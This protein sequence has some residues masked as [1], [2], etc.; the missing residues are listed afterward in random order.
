MQLF[1]K[2]SI[3]KSFVYT[4]YLYPIAIAIIVVLWIWG[5]SAFHAPSAHQELAIFFAA[6]VHNDSF[7]VSIMNNH[8]EREKLRSITSSYSSVGSAGFVDKLKIAMNNAD[9]MILDEDTLGGF[10]H[11]YDQ[12]LV[13]FSDYVK[14]NYLDSDHNYYKFDDKDYGLLIKEKGVE[15]YLNNYM[16]FN[17]EKDYYL[18]LNLASSNLG[19]IINENNAYYDNALTYMNYLVEG[20]L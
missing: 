17:E 11:Y 20:N 5:F 12:T 16:T 8:Y 2:S 3:K 7:L 19:S 13:E 14:D 18:V 6:N 4:W 1:N 15:C 10:I 9:I